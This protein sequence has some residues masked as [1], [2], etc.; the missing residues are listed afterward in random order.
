MA[1]FQQRQYLH[2]SQFGEFRPDRL[3][4]VDLLVSAAAG[5]FASLP[6]GLLMI[7]LNRT[8]L[9][10]RVLVIDEDVDSV[11]DPEALSEAEPPKQITS[12]MATRVGVE[13]AIHPG[14]EWETA[15]WL[16][17]LGY[18]AAT[19]S[20]YPFF[21]RLLNAGTEKAGGVRFPAALRGMVFAL[22]VW[23]GSYMG[24]LPAANILPPASQQPARRNTVMIVSHLLWGSLIGFL[25]NAAGDKF[26]R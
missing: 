21:D 10:N 25:V 23:A 6:M 14:R 9:K 5:F 26:N 22:L 17:H 8:L 3:K 16:S 7:G 13:R 2:R 15:T 1:I 20:V 12:V 18:G 24:W 4:P 11:V 19:A